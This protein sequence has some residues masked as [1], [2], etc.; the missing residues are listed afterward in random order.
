MKKS[1]KKDQIVI[2]ETVYFGIE[3]A[4]VIKGLSYYVDRC[5]VRT[6]A[7]L[8]IKDEICIKNFSFIKIDLSLINSID[9][10]LIFNGPLA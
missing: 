1:P 4:N 2:G 10:Q 7:K 3:P 6:V 9:I 5:D 8:I